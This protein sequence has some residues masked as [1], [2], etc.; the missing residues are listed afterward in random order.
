MEPLDNNLPWMPG[1]RRGFLLFALLLVGTTTVAF[2]LAPR[3]SQVLPAPLPVLAV[4]ALVTL[5]CMPPLWYGAA[6]HLRGAA[7]RERLRGQRIVQH[8]AEGILTISKRGQILSMNPAAERLFGW[9]AAE[10]LHEPVTRLIAEPTARDRH[11]P[12]HDS[13]PVGTILGL[14]AGAREVI[15]FRKGGDTFPLELTVGTMPLGNEHVTVAFTR[16]VSKRK[17]A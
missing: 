13:L 1:L 11:N 14:A 6:R 10:V 7:Q 2:T 5:L 16:D 12:L 15:G 3:L 9:R 8:A 17:Q 4:T